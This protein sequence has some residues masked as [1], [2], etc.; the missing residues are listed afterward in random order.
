MP[1]AIVTG[2]HFVPVMGAAYICRNSVF[3]HLGRNL[4]TGGDNS[5]WR[6]GLVAP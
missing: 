2:A 1:E 5:A 3:P 4:N 6:D